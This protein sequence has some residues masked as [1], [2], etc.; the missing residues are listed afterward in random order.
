[1]KNYLKLTAQVLFASLFFL[2]CSDDDE[3]KQDKM[4]LEYRV[5]VETVANPI[6]TVVY[7]GSDGQQVT[8]NPDDESISIQD[9]MTI[10]SKTISV[11][12]PF[13]AQMH[14]EMQNN[15]AVAVPFRISIS[16]DGVEVV[17][18]DLVIPANSPYQTDL[19]Y[20]L[21]LEE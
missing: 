13:E 9:G 1:M 2:S 18:D 15:S 17:S 11:D 5:S 4:E 12:P 7:T 8:V 3:K 16:E 20:A 10:F 6:L 14:V 19:S 21:L